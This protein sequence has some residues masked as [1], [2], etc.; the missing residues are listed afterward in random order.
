MSTDP[1][2]TS[3]PCKS[4]G[5]GTDRA[6][7][8]WAQEPHED[9]RHGRGRLRGRRQNEAVRDYAAAE[10][11]HKG[12]EQR[13]EHEG[14]REPTKDPQFPYV[15]SVRGL[16]EA[17]S[18][19]TGLLRFAVTLRV[20]TEWGTA[21]QALLNLQFLSWANWDAPQRVIEAQSHS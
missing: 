16:R 1:G 11:R 8:A 14:L 13:F 17:Q 15:H 2:P 19:S 7:G 18:L 9:R 21:G 3:R 5:T 6:S 12:R 20:L 10:G 4:V